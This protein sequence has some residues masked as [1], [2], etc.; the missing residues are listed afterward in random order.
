MGF[1]FS[2]EQCLSLKIPFFSSVKKSVLVNVT[3]IGQICVL[4]RCFNLLKD[5]NAFQGSGSW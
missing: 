5:T 3:V 2:H 4:L 1:L